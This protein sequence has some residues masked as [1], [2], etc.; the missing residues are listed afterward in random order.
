M[1]QNHCS[2][3]NNAKIMGF[4][5]KNPKKH[6]YTLNIIPSNNNIFINHCSTW[7]TT[8]LHTIYTETFPL[9]LCP[10]LKADFL[11]L[12]CSTWNNHKNR[13]TISRLIWFFRICDPV[14]HP[15]VRAMFH[16][17][18]PRKRLQPLQNTNCRLS[19]HAKTP[20]FHVEQWG[21]GKAKIAVLT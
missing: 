16:V 19:Y 11:L 12:N 9:Q 20:L 14:T 21:S 15:I 4:P 17:E 3:W 6:F 10:Y 7:N 2:T 5:R 1:L 8:K 13:F 18:H